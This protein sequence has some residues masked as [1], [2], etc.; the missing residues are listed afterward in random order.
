MKRKSKIA[1]LTLVLGAMIGG[2][3]VI[4]TNVVFYYTSTNESCEA[5]H[6]HPG[7]YE[8]WKKSVHHNSKHGVVTNCVDCHLPEHGTLGYYKAKVSTGVK[9]IWSYMTKD[10]TEINWA[11]K[12]EL[13]AA[14][15]FV[16]NESCI[17]C[18]QSIFPSGLNDK[19]LTSHLYYEENAEKL[20]LQC[21]G[22]HLDVGHYDPNYSHSQMTSIPSA[23]NKAKGPLF[24]EATVVTSYE[25]FTEKVPGTTVSFNMKAIPAGTFKMGSPDKEQLRKDDEGPVR[26][27]TLSPFFMSE[28]EVTWDQYWAFFAET[29]SEGRTLPSKVYANNS[30]DPAVDAISGPTP[31]FGIPDQGWGSGDRP[32]ITMTHYAAEIFCMWLSKKTGKNYRL[33]TEAEWEYA[34]RGGTE[35]PYFFKGNPNDYYS[36]NFWNKM[37]GVDTTNINTYVVYMENSSNRTDEPNS[38]S[39]NPFG[40]KNMY[41]NVM[42]YCVDKYAPDAYSK[43]GVDV[44]DPVNTDSSSESAEY[45]VRGGDFRSDA[46]QL[47]SAARGFTEHDKWLKT[48]PQQPKSIWWY[49]DIK[50]I[51]FRVVCTID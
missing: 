30:S 32:A 11:A 49:S 42:E 2:A 6:V 37:F 41:G 46:D 48:D 45:V 14:Q 39:A 20:G 25:N 38:V 36:Q 8:S 5:C 19:G 27:V 26:N 18:H 34:A 24:E 10:S 9:D 16:Y 47:R 50:S 40:L 43:T 22:C 13:E 17:R 21:I 7:S 4:G 15:K 23:N 29:L 51:G 35:T 33:P 12:N 31:P 3:V 44:K 1:I 28:I